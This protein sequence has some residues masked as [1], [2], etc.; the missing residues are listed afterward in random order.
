MGVRSFA[1]IARGSVRH[2]AHSAHKISRKEN[3]NRS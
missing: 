2:G 1:L 3:K